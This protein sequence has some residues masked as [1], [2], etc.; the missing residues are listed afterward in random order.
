MEPLSDP[1]YLPN[2]G[3]LAHHGMDRKRMD[4]QQL[5][6]ILLTG[7]ALIA[8]AANSLLGR[9]ALENALIDPLSFTTLRLVSGSLVLLMLAKRLRGSQIL[10][11][12]SWISALALFVYAAAFSL[13]YVSLAAGMGALIL[14]G[15]VQGTMLGAAVRTGE[16]LQ[17][18][19]WIGAMLAMGGLIYLVSPGIT[20]PDPTGALLMVGSG[21]AWGLYSI[22]GR[23]VDQPV[24][25]TAGNFTRAAPLGIGVSIIACSA[26]DLQ[27][28]GMLLALISGGITSGLGYALWY[29]VLRTLTT[30]QASILQLL[31]PV[32]AASGGVILLTEPVSLRLIGAGV[33]IL[34]GVTL[35]ILKGPTTRSRWD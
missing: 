28:L 8:F 6:T 11:S 7:L 18:R 35:G 29:R 27:P 5:F 25:M 17:L 33:L 34:G 10:T 1:V 30:A 16:R 2:T 15:S 12:G 21:I 14:F 22:R 13:A 23:G 26:I 4:H 31:V 3:T 32:L 24:V 20:A 9:L 19:Q